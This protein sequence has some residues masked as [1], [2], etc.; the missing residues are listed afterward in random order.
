MEERS[1]QSS[2]SE[3]S[4]AGEL[5]ATFNLGSTVQQIHRMESLSP[6]SSGLENEQFK[7]LGKRVS[8]LYHL[9]HH[10]SKRQQGLRFN[11]KFY[12]FLSVREPSHKIGISLS[13]LTRSGKRNR[14]LRSSVPWREN[15]WYSENTK[16]RKNNDTPYPDIPWSYKI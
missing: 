2:L 4:G 16:V 6:L 11:P 1:F 5:L 13:S 15:S 7:F 10:Y 12:P 8:K 3:Q 14:I 9:H